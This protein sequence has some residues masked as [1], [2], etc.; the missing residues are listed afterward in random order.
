MNFSEKLT[1]LRKRR[2][3]SQEQ[4]AELLNVKPL[5][6]AALMRSITS[7]A[8]YLESPGAAEATT[9]VRPT[10]HALNN[11]SNAKKMLSVFFASFI[12]IF[13]SEIFQPFKCCYICSETLK[14]VD[15]TASELADWSEL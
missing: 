3:L 11:I 6:V 8:A 10:E 9:P 15:V 2:G 7:L 13:L 12:G 14:N 5:A 1:I 4:L